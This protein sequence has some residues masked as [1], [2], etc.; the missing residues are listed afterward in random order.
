MSNMIALLEK[1]ENF[2]SDF[3]TFK[4]EFETFKKQPDRTPVLN[5]FNKQSDV[6]DNKLELIRN[7][8]KRK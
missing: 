5:K 3:E 4:K 6:L 2:K 8:Y 7:S 1:M